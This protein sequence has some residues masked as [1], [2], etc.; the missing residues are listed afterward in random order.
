MP[1]K[2]ARPAAKKAAKRRSENAAKKHKQRRHIPP[3]TMA[4]HG[5]AIAAMSTFAARNLAMRRDPEINI[6]INDDP[7]DLYES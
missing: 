6:I 2:N 1:R 4:M 5:A 3:Q 7:Q